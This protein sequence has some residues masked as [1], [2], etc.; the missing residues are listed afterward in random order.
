[1]DVE[2]ER[3]ILLVQHASGCSTSRSKVQL[4][5]VEAKCNNF[6]PPDLEWVKDRRTIIFL[7]QEDS[8]ANYATYV[9][10][11]IVGVFSFLILAMLRQLV[12]EV[13]RGMHDSSE[14]TRRY[15]QIPDRSLIA[16]I[17]GHHGNAYAGQ[18]VDYDILFLFIST[19]SCRMERIIATANPEVYHRTK[20]A[21]SVLIPLTIFLIDFTFLIGRLAYQWNEF[22]IAGTF[23]LF[24]DIMTI[25]TNALSV[26]YNRQR[27]QEAFDNLN[28][29]YQAKEAF[30][31]SSAMQPIYIVIFCM[32]FVIVI[33]SIICLGMNDPFFNGYN[34]AFYTTVTAIYAS[35]VAIMLIKKHP[36]LLKQARLILGIRISVAPLPPRNVCY[37]QDHFNILNFRLDSAHVP[38]SMQKLIIFVAILKIAYGSCPAGLEL[39]RDG[40]CRGLYATQSI[41]DFSQAS[42]V[43]IAKC[44]EIHGKPVIIHNEEHQDYY[45][46]RMPKYQDYNYLILGLVCNYTSKRWIWADGSLI[47]YRKPAEGHNQAL[48]KECQQGETWMLTDD[49]YW[50][51]GDHWMGTSTIYIY[52]TTQLEQPK[53]DGCES[54]DDDVE[55]GECYQVTE[56]AQTWK[57]AQTT[58]RN[59]GANVASIHNLQENSFIRRLAVSKGAV[60][61]MYIGGTPAGKGNQFGWIDGTDWDYENWYPGYPVNGGGDCLAM[62][63]LS[64]AGQWMNQDCSSSLAVACARDANPRPTCHPGPWKEGEVIYSPGYPFDASL[65]CDYFLTVVAGKRVQV[66]VILLEANTCCDHLL[67]EDDVLGGNLVANLTGEVSN[68]IFTT[69]K[70]N[71][72][73]VSWHPNGGVNVRGMMMTFQHVL[74]SC[75][76]G[77][78]L[79]RDGECRGFQGTI[80]ATFAQAVLNVTDTCTAIQGKP[81]IIRNDE[82]QS[83]WKKM[84]TPTDKGYLIIGLVCNST[85]KRWD[86]ADGSLA[87]SAD[88]RPT[89]GYDDVFDQ[90]CD[91]GYSW[92][93]DNTGYWKKGNS[94]NMFTNIQAYCTTQLQQPSGDG[95]DSFADDGADGFCYQVI[96]TTQTWQDAV[97]TCQNIA[98]TIASIH[99][100]QENSFIR[101]LAVSN[102]ALNGVYIGAKGTGN[103]YSW[104]DGSEWDYKNFYPGFPING[105]GN[106][107]AMDT[108]APTGEWMNMD[109]NSKL[110]VACQR[111]AIP[112]PTCS[113][114]PWMEGET[115]YSPG[116]PYDSSEPCDY[117]LSVERGKN[118]QIEIQVLEANSCCDYLVIEDQ[119]LGGNII[120]KSILY[121]KRL[122]K[123]FS[124]TGEISNKK[125]TTMLSNFA[126][127]SWQPNGG[128]N[129]RDDLPRSVICKSGAFIMII[130]N[131]ITFFNMKFLLLAVSLLHFA[132]SS[133]PSGFDLIRDGECRGQQGTISAWFSQASSKVVDKCKTISGQPGIIHND[134]H[135]L[136]WKKQAPPSNKGY[137]ILGLVCNANTKRWEWADGSADDYRPSD[138]YHPALDDVCKPNWSWY[139]DNFGYWDLGNS[140]STFTVQVFCTVQLQQPVG[141]GCD[142]FGDDSGDHMC[143]QVSATSQSWQDAQAACQDQGATVASIHNKQE[144]TFI[145]NLAVANGAMNGVYIG[146]KGVGNQFSWIDGSAWDYKNFYPGFPVNGKGD[147]LAMDTFAPTGEW[148]NMD[149]NSK[150][151]VACAKIGELSRYFWRGELM[152]LPRPT[153]TGGP[154]KEGET[155]YSPG[156]PYDASASCDYQFSVAA[157][158]MVQVE[159][160]QLEANTCCDFLVLEDKMMGGNI[161]A[162]LT[163]EIYNK[164]YTTSSSNFMRVSWLPNGGV[165]V[166]GVMMTFRGV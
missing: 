72:M 40:E 34:E 77:Y 17:A 152:P 67:M 36:Q 44:A 75:P 46:D 110:A 103:Q 159:I 106:C 133:C 118:V 37:T 92:Y 9:A 27:F 14:A 16:S 123:P 146:A 50:G 132:Y 125:Y 102:G 140:N 109:C 26:K 11:P 31:L 134:E 70:S 122:C 39:V 63:T 143:Y 150:M 115:I 79:I 91:S 29:K 82:H 113:A 52:C 2:V 4:V 10:N 100:S 48:D 126:R 112:R 153:C 47:D 58:C 78:D 65:G 7:L 99:N 84:A 88:F 41:D 56:K 116:Y 19:K 3:K 30:Q 87:S 124:L 85:T 62:D 1:M 128:V 157:G 25:V 69:D 139:I 156:Y 93:M 28:A 21:M 35:I 107:L 32:K 136:Y 165:N 96:P 94:K 121:S 54:F 120:A 73:R 141:D 161:V 15:Q 53:G 98:S 43:A 130:E 142:S 68:K 147:C 160:Q 86:W 129:V 49:G 163:G 42:A 12:S 151:A 162:N 166:R 64:S 154:W 158:K 149:C 105:R 20:L 76:A 155:I 137:F 104:M 61:G 135:Q 144:N 38:L 138:G 22:E 60:N 74:S 81:V 8:N 114:G 6:L 97:E 45:A 111:R 51:Y 89:D 148:L 24:C 131:I 117:L 66:E 83:Y 23:L 101:K 57:E 127:V 80:S 90:Y 59:L 13:K 108:F 33:S 18:F 95:C 119:L 164:M 5:R 71:L 145:R 55:D